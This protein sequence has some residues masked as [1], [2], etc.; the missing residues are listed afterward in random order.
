MR[1]STIRSERVVMASQVGLGA[2]DLA[3][4]ACRDLAG[5]VVA[6]GWEG[7]ADW[8]D[9]VEAGGCCAGAEMEELVGMV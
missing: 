9:L 8:E 1:L 5:L 3:E 4:W 7:L 2:L 6:D